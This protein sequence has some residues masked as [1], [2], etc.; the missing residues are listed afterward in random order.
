MV[1]QRKSQLAIWRRVAFWIGKATR[2]QPHV[3]A[4]HPHPQTHARAH[5]HT[6]TQK[7]VIL[8]AFTW[9][10]LCRERALML[11]YMSVVQP[12]Y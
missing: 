4:R 3:R 11:R 2:A 5:A 7:C 9:Q 12:Q 10:Q 1:Q 6:H 8:T